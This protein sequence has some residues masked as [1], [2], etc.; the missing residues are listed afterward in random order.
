MT[1]YDKINSV[2]MSLGIAIFIAGI[3]YPIIFAV[4][5][6]YCV[7]RLLIQ[8]FVEKEQADVF[9]VVS[10]LLTGPLS[11]VAELVDYIGRMKE[12]DKLLM[13]LKEAGENYGKHD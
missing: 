12:A 11:G 8:R 4:Y 5:L 6:I 7:G 3:F 1:V 2:L 9:V 13:K 10:L